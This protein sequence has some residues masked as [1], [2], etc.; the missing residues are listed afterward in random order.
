MHAVDPSGIE[1]PPRN[2]I[3]QVEVYAN[4]LRNIGGLRQLFTEEESEGLI[5]LGV[6]LYPLGDNKTHEHCSETSACV[7][8]A[9]TVFAPNFGRD[10]LTDPSD[11]IGQ[12]RKPMTQV[13]PDE[14]IA[15]W[16]RYLRPLEGGGTGAIPQSPR[17]VSLAS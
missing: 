5:T 3:Y 9:E 4:Q 7:G 12:L 14:V 8:E 17:L 10:G 13:I 1:F 2:P 16:R 6:F 11:L 15:E